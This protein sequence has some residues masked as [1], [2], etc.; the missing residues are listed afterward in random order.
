MVSRGG[1]MGYSDDAATVLPVRVSRGVPWLV[2]LVVALALVA[3]GLGIF[4]RGGDGPSPFTT[5][6]GQTVQLD[7]RGIYRNDTRFVAAG[8]RGTD[9]VTLVLGMPL[10]IAAAACYRR[11]SLRGALL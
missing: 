8:N 9:A 11:G 10:L 6:R 4:S 3:A 2:A 7:G 1:Y 5:L